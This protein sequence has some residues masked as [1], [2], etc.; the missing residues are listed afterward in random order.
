MQ[1]RI[2]MI[3]MIHTITIAPTTPKIENNKLEF[4]DP[5]L[6]GVTVDCVPL[7]VTVDCFMLFEVAATNELSIVADLLVITLDD[8]SVTV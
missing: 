2:T 8:L 7:L 6:D 5:L 1:A 3:A 4:I